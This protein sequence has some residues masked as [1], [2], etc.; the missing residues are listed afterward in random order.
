MK[1]T[2]NVQATLLLTSRLVGVSGTDVRPL[3]TGEWNRLLVWLRDRDMKSG[4]RLVDDPP[5]NVA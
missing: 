2:N 4:D 3:T 5:G 1:M